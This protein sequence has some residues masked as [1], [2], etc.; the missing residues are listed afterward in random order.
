MAWA[1]DEMGKPNKVKTSA[2]ENMVLFVTPPPTIRIPQSPLANLEH[3][4]A[5]ILINSLGRARLL[6]V[7]ALTLFIRMIAKGCSRLASGDCG[8]R[9]VGGRLA[10]Y[11][12]IPR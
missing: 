11:G 8:M 2:M 5:I 3:P 6:V 1:W 4:F 10:R 12:T 7:L 9:I